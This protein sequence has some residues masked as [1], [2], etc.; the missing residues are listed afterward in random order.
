LLPGFLRF[1]FDVDAEH[2]GAWRE[3]GGDAVRTPAVHAVN[4][5]AASDLFTPVGP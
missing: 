5:L 2:V 1:G 3:D 4:H